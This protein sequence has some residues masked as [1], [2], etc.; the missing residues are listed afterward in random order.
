MLFPSC[1]SYWTCYSSLQTKH[2]VYGRTLSFHNIRIQSERIKTLEHNQTIMTPVTHPSATDLP[3]KKKVRFEEN[4][5]VVEVWDA[6]NEDEESKDDEQL[7]DFL[8]L[9]GDGNNNAFPLLT[10]SML[11]RSV[12]RPSESNRSDR[13]KESRQ[14]PAFIPFHHHPQVQGTQRKRKVR[15]LT[16]GISSRQSPSPVTGGCS[17]IISSALEC[18]EGIDLNY[19]WCYKCGYIWTYRNHNTSTKELYILPG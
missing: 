1:S 10:R 7:C 5:Q 19:P 12:V 8:I 16:G 15:S 11:S 18:L 2:L 17:D 3:I 13:L 9:F 6:L 14:M 4:E